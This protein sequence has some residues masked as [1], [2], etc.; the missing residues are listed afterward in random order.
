M[1]DQVR[2]PLEILASPMDTFVDLASSG[3]CENI[4]DFDAIL[5]VHAATAS[6]DLAGLPVAEELEEDGAV[7][8]VDLNNA[9]L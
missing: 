7:A 1:V 5:L 9:V 3:L 4:V 6:M 8:Q 2:L